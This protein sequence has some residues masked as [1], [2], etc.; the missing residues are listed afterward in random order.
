MAVGLDRGV[1]RK[2][3]GGRKEPELP[4]L[5]KVNFPAIW[6]VFRIEGKAW[7]AARAG[8]RT[9]H[10]CCCVPKTFFVLQK[11]QKGHF[12]SMKSEILGVL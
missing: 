10:I 12:K 9:L 3:G 11:P 2:A 4:D 7:K 6:S 1:V 8:L 5:N